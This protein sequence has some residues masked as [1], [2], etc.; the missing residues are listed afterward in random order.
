MSGKRSH[1]SSKS[2]IERAKEFPDD[3]YEDSGYLFCKYCQKSINFKLVSY[4]HIHAKLER[5]N[6][7][8]N[9]VFV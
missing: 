4:I 6:I 1:I 2:A 5:R 8:E 7:H 3:F 9:I